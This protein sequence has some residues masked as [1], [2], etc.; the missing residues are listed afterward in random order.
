MRC[1]RLEDQGVME[2]I[3]FVPLGIRRKDFPLQTLPVHDPDR[4]ARL[5]EYRRLAEKE[6]DLQEYMDG[7][8]NVNM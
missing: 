5:D 7:H 6:I 4:Q 1:Y 3:I 8:R 2:E